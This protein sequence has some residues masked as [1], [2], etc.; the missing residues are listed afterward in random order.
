MVLHEVLAEVLP[1]E[2]EVLVE[3]LLVEEVSEE[4]SEVP[5]VVNNFL[6]NKIVLAIFALFKNDYDCRDFCGLIHDL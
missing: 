5:E 6:F 3:E 1:V 2:E 4:D